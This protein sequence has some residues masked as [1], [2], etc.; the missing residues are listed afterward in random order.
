MNV[1]YTV[2]L[3]L[4][5]AFMPYLIHKRWDD[6]IQTSSS[7]LLNDITFLLLT[8][9]FSEP[10]AKIFNVFWLHR[11]F[12]RKMI[13]KYEPRDCPY[14]QHEANYWHEGPTF[15]IAN[16]YA[17]I[18]RTLFLCTWY[19]SVAPYGLIFSFVGKKNLAKSK[20]NCFL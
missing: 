11:I 3:F 16:S 20:P 15:Y 18:A 8:N 1:R 10:L 9:A 5:S 7:L 2:L 12:M 6:D 14:T 17:Y 13:T 19:A 4:N